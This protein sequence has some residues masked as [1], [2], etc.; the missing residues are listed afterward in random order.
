VTVS[1]PKG[2]A[3]ATLRI[4]AG[5][6]KLA[7]TP[8]LGWN[9]WNVWGLA[10]DDAK[11]R[12]AADAMVSSGLA[13]RGFAFVNIDDGWEKGRDAKGEILTNERFPDMKALADYVHAKGLKLGIYSSPGPKTCGGHEGSYGHE[14]QDA[15][16]WARWGIDYLKYDWCSY[17]EI[18]KGDGSLAT[19]QKPY[20]VMRAA[21]DAAD[22]DVVFSL[23]QYG[24]GDVWRWGPSVGGNLWRTTGDITDTWS[25][26]NRIG[27]GQA[28][29][30]PFAAPGHW[31][32]PDMLVVGRVGW[33]P[34]VRPS[35][36]SPNEQVTHITLWSMLAAPMLI[37][38]DLAQL[39]Q[40]TID[41]LTNDEVLAVD[42]DPLGKQGR[43]VR[44]DEDG[45]EVWA[46]ELADGTVAVALFNRGAEAAKVEARWK[47]LA[48]AGTQAVRDLWAKKDVG[49][50]ADAW[51]T[52][53][54]RHGA[55]LL[56]VGTPRP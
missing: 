48:L 23:C 51:G 8:P 44:A 35:R 32:D 29:L 17:G 56:K 53:V 42:Q 3:A 19:L 33:G 40:V 30:F 2:R 6:G 12:A 52:T 21:L 1:G 50:F 37:G 16:T 15:R 45:R 14:E 18:V 13:A 5:P 7:Q 31:N 46:R 27:F 4:E 54:P 38:A 47:D 41:L 24:M 36:L 28:E 25:S 9:S 55:V 11:V 22:R 10:V 20:A 39:D 26:L 34:K 49:R 43:R